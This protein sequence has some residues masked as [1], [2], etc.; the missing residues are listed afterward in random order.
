MQNSSGKG[1]VLWELNGR[2]VAT[3]TLN[4]PQVNNAYNGDLVA[5]KCVYGVINDARASLAELAFQFVFAENAIHTGSPTLASVL[6]SLK[7][8]W[9]PSSARPGSRLRSA[10]WA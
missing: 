4:R 1:T 7:V 5:G 8:A 9:S 6:R 2:G 10:G 3:V